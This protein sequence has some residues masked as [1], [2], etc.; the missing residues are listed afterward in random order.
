MFLKSG[1]RTDVHRLFFFFPE[2]ND[3]MD[4]VEQM[5]IG[6]FFF[7]KVI[8][9]QTHERVGMMG[10]ITFRVFYEHFSNLQS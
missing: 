4:S 2:S 5:L 6:Y 7:P 3:N 10:M 9:K 1:S 8:T